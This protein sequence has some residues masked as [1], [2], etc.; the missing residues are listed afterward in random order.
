[1]VDG[2]WM[3]SDRAQGPLPRPLFL[4][5]ADSAGVK[6]AVFSMS[7]DEVVSAD[8][9]GVM[10]AIRLQKG[11]HPGNADSREF[12]RTVWRAR[13]LGRHEETEANQCSHYSILVPSVNSYL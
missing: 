4:V 3:A 10:G 11:K 5:S 9:N 13:I 7:W 8:S 6:A 12:R 1:M 2:E